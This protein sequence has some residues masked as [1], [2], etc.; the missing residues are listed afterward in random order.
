MAKFI[1]V[2]QAALVAA[3]L[4]APV[5]TTAVHAQPATTTPGMTTIPGTG[6]TY[7][8]VGRTDGFNWGWLGLIGLAGLAPLFMR[9]DRH[10][11]IHPDT[12]R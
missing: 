1:R 11:T 7:T 6:G 4:S 8:G 10:A 2:C 3:L 5:L 9:R 12:R